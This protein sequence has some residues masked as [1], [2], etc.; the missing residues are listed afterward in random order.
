MADRSRPKR[1]PTTHACPG[2]CG[3]QV[4]R[5]LLACRSCWYLLPKALRDEVERH[6]IGSGAHLAAVGEALVWYREHV[7]DGSLIE[8]EETS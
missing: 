7:A 5:R 6:R 8:E 4:P 1:P 2:D 3:E